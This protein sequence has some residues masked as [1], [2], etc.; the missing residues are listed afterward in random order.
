MFQVVSMATDRVVLAAN[1]EFWEGKP[2]VDGLEF[3]LYETEQDLLK[4]YHSKLLEHGVTG[5]SYKKFI[6][7]Y[8]TNLVVILVMFSMSMDSDFSH[9]MALPAEAALQ[10]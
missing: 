7:G 1:P 2:F 3:W 10:T 5:Y 8:K 6:N 9:T 4:L